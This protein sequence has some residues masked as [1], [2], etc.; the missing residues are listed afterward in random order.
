MP[1]PEDSPQEMETPEGICDDCPWRR[2]AAPG[3]LGSD[4]DAVDWLATAHSDD[5][6]ECHKRGGCHCVGIAVYRK[7]VAK[8]ARFPNPEDIEADREAVFAGPAEFHEYH[9]HGE[10]LPSDWTIRRYQ[11]LMQ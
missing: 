6:V 9:T 5:T 10:E 11:K 8:L 4:Q 1:L 7:N 2:N 3:W